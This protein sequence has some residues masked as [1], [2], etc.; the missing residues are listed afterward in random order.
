MLS[1]VCQILGVSHILRSD[2]NSATIAQKCD[3]SEVKDRDPAL[4]GSTG[5]SNWNGWADLS[6]TNTMQTRY[7]WGD[8][9][10]EL[11]ARISSSGT[12]A[13]LLTDHLGSIVGVTNSS[14][15][16]IDT[17]AYD[18][19]GNITS[20][21]SPSN[22]GTYKYG[23]MEYDA[24]TG[25][26]Y[27]RARYYDATT[28]RWITQ[29]PWGF[30]AGAGNLYQYANN[31]PTNW[32]DPSGDVPVRI[33]RSQYPA[34]VYSDASGAFI[35]YLDQQG[36]V[37]RH[38]GQNNGYADWRQVPLSTVE[39]SSRFDV[40]G[41]DWWFRDTDPSLAVQAPPWERNRG[42]A[43]PPTAISPTSPPPPAVAPPMRP[44]PAPVVTQEPEPAPAGNAGVDPGA[45]TRD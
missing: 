18:A 28:G 20:E 15:S 2:D 29:D 11:F 33:D 44:A 23:G 26:Y 32:T 24:T 16:M 35:G 17:I 14:G 31:A 19:F 21:S 1:A 12:A 6:S 7:L 43:V 9:V 41:W 30:G 27:S 4:A 45:R 10:N 5:N 22:G 37:W 42:R 38:L 39:N 13:F 25:L 40:R 34:E 8:Q 3:P 36:N